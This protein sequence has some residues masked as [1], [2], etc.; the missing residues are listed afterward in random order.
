M[1]RVDV[2]AE[3]DDAA[4]A[5]DDLALTSRA[6][7]LLGARAAVAGLID[8][9]SELR[10]RQRDYLQGPKGER[11]DF[12]GRLVGLAAEQLDAAIAKATGATP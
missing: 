4:D 1:I 7:R 5:L 10:L 3:M 8:A 2:L 11:S 6:E 9:A 12:K